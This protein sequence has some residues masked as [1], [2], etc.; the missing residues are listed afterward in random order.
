MRFNAPH[1]NINGEFPINSL[2]HLIIKHF[3]LR[4][5]RDKVLIS[6]F[7]RKPRRHFQQ[8]GKSLPA[9][10]AGPGIESIEGIIHDKHEVLI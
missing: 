1:F 7:I 2:T 4:G 8:A 5:A 9:L 3:F 6:V 10:P